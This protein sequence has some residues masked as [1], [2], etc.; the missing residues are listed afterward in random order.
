MAN[1]SIRI[2][3]RST[4]LWWRND[5][6]DRVTTPGRFLARYDRALPGE[7]SFYQA[8]L[9]ALLDEL[10]TSDDGGADVFPARL[11]AAL[12]DVRTPSR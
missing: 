10:V 8:K 1:G 2:E 12:Y 9:A 4:A 7:R 11:S 3:H 6:A 5:R